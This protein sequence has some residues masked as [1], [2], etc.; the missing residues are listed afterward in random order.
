M[1]KEERD[2]VA[3]IVLWNIAAIVCFTILS[4]A[5]NKWWIV[6]FSALFYK[7]WNYKG[8]NKNGKD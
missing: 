6:L 7:G 3:L 1:K 2:I 5:F 8:G 4:V